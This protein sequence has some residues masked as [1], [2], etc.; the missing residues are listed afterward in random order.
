MLLCT[1]E[2]YFL[3]RVP[4][5][6][7]SAYSHEQPELQVVLRERH[8]H[9]DRFQLFSLITGVPNQHLKE[10]RTLCSPYE[11]SKPRQYLNQVVSAHKAGRTIVQLLR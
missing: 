4:V 10:L 6:S 8:H 9:F 1:Y 11:M 3:S 2:E 7:I 5:N